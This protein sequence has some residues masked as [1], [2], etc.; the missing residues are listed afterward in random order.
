MGN[1]RS[2]PEMFWALKVS[3]LGIF[4]LNNITFFWQK[5]A[6]QWTVPSDLF[7]KNIHYSFY[8]VVVSSG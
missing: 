5:L 7:A 6:S 8:G 1:A 3:I 4:L 2:G